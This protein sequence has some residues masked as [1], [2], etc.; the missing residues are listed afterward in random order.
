MFASGSSPS[1]ERSPFEALIAAGVVTRLVAA[2]ALPVGS[3]PL[4]SVLLLAAAATLPIL[5]AALVVRVVL[6]GLG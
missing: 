6:G 2:L 3:M 1:R 4:G 5:L